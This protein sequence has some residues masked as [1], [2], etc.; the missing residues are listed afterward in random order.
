M[1]WIEENEA[2]MDWLFTGSPS[3]MLRE[4]W[5]RR[6]NERDMIDTTSKLE[7]EI[8]AGFLALLTAVV[9]HKLPLEEPE[10]LFALGTLRPP[11]I[12]SVAR[13]IFFRWYSGDRGLSGPVV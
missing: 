8:Q 1:E 11:L 12:L 7:P 5:K 3:G 2:D 9:V 4:C 10:Q 13:T 6:I